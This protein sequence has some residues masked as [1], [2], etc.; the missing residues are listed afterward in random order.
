MMKACLLLN[1][2]NIKFDFFFI[3]KN[4]FFNEYKYNVFENKN[5]LQNNG[6]T[7]ISLCKVQYLRIN[8][9]CFHF[10]C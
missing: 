8:V 1:L 3:V 9:Y 7:I 2:K 6:N 4:N 10:S 5:Y